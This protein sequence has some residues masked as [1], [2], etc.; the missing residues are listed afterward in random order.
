MRIAYFYVMTDDADHVRAVAPDHAAYWRDRH[1]AGYV[2]GPMADRTAGLITFETASIE[3]AQ[4]FVDDDPFVRSGVLA[5]L[6]VKEWVPA[7]DDMA[8]RDLRAAGPGRTAGDST[9]RDGAAYVA[10]R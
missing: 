4:S 1:P 5:R 8:E 9:H 10:G 3:E 6:W 2:G 7:S